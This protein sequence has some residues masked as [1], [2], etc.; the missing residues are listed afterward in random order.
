MAKR[1]ASINC[2]GRQAKAELAKL[3]G[4][5]HAKT[6]DEFP[7]CRDGQEVGFGGRGG[8]GKGTR[9]PSAYQAFIGRCMKERGVKSFGE[10]PAAMKHCAG[11]W[12]KS[13]GR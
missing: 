6:I 12:R 7:A 2:L 10:A 13:K 9:A 5:E 1:R 4:P 3:L 8:G 11:E